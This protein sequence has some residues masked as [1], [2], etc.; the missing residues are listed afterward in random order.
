M[1]FRVETMQ[2][3]GCAATITQALGALDPDLSVVA[4]V[5][6]KRIRVGGAVTAEALVSA[7]KAAGHTA[8][9]IGGE[10][11]RKSLPLF[12]LKF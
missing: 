11:A 9:Q 2:C 10:P 1:E 12:G 5:P 3:G 8:V 7:L 6:G 4:D